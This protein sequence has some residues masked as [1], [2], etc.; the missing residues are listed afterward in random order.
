ML[1]LAL[2][3]GLLASAA[4]PSA[5]AALPAAPAVVPAAPAAVAADTPDTV[6]LKK[7]GELK[8]R[9]VYEDDVMLL[10]RI[11]TKEKQIAQAE[12]E[13]V[14]AITRSLHELLDKLAEVDGTA[15]GP[16][17]VDGLMGL[18]TFAQ[19]NDLPGEARL[20]FLRVLLV[21]PEHPGAN[22]ALGNREKEGKWTLTHDKRQ[23]STSELAKVGLDWGSRWTLETT[24]YKLLSNLALPAA[25]HAAFDLERQYRAFYDFLQQHLRLLDITEEKLVVELHGDSDSYPEPGDGRQA[26]FDGEAL[27]LYV[28]ASRS[29]NRGSL[30]HEAAHQLLYM[31][32]KRTRGGKG[33][34][35]A[36][37]DEGMGEYFRAALKG[38]AGHATFEFGLPLADHLKTIREADKP[39]DL[40]RV[41]TFVATD[42][43]VSTDANL[44]YAES[45][46]L[47]QY[48]LHGAD[49]AH[50]EAFMDF[51]KSA[52]QGKSSMTDFK[53]AIEMDIDDFEKA[54]FTWV[55]QSG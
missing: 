5:L 19:D 55:R 23:H 27:A 52:Y 26:Y 7:G 3:A 38:A 54:F 46:A 1:A 36:W 41:L 28:E 50:R 39:L 37:L 14:H 8:G 51:I 9:V 13:S 33:E 42:F 24:H 35:P 22:A 45:W 49:G 21:A 10:L 48:G 12:I 40:N 4:A 31:T 30:A 44:K 18:A 2:L 6:T 17:Q 16:A 32:T 43:L 47:L 53:K 11:G 25:I 20:L 29:L 15:P 34:I